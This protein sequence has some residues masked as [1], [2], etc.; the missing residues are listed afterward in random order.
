MAQIGTIQIA[1]VA[2]AGPAEVELNTLA[3]RTVIRPSDLRYLGSYGIAVPVVNTPSLAGSTSNVGACGL[4]NP[5]PDKVVAI[6]RV[7]ASLVMLT[8]A[9]ASASEGV[10]SL[11]VTRDV[12]IFGTQAT[13]LPN[14]VPTNQAPVKLRSTMPSSATQVIIQNSLSAGTGKGIFNGQGAGTN[15]PQLPS[16][17]NEL[18]GV[19]TFP[20]LAAIGTGISNIPFGSDGISGADLFDWK[21]AN[22]P[23]MLGPEDGVEVTVSAISATTTVF[24]INVNW[25]WDEYG[26][27]WEDLRGEGSI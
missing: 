27:D 26:F 25:M 10:L 11:Q 13:N 1:G 2:N 15:G 22:A 7:R 19:I 14:G 24:H 9:P 17:D 23:L 16:A 4:Y 3:L 5:A 21:A 12:T 8:A 18:H 6:K 20:T